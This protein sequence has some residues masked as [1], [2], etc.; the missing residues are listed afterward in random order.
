[1]A[2]SVSNT[3]WSNFKTSDYTDEQYAR[4][5]LLD[6]GSNAGTAKQ[7]F[8][9]PVRE[10]SGVVNSNGAHAAA[11]VLSSVGGA[12]NARGNK[13]SATPAQLAVARRKLVDIYRNV[14]KEPLPQGLMAHSA[15]DDDI[16][17]HHGI[18][19][20]RWGVRRRNPSGPESVSVKL[21]KHGQIAKTS[22][23]RNQPAHE[24]AIRAAIGKRVVKSS[25]T[26]ALSNQQLQDLVTRMNLESQ[27]GR[28]STGRKSSGQKFA[29]DIV[30][31]VGK[32]QATK[33]ASDY[34]TKAIAA[35]LKKA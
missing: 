22:G 28:L 34:A 27:Y 21:N 16:L 30:V 4:A 33:L 1:M 26:H 11:A 32:Q 18:K 12:G 23:G 19:G 24:D 20:Q 14:L 2:E 9:I 17:A 13:L 15:M 8:G 7:R 29:E 25:G 5:C 35:S 3:P 10:P 6:R 31:G